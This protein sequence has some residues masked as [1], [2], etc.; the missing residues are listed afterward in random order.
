MA[1]FSPPLATISGSSI[2]TAPAL[3]SGTGSTGSG[4]SGL[5]SPIPVARS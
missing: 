2:C 5:T 4:S 3:P 1:P